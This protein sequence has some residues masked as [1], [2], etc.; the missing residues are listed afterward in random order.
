ML[1]AVELGLPVELLVVVVFVVVEADSAV[2]AVVAE[3]GVVV[4]A[5]TLERIVAQSA[6]T[7]YSQ[8]EEGRGRENHDDG[9]DVVIVVD[10]LA[11]L[12]GSVVQK[13]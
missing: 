4:V 10:P 11:A 12:A 7:V 6:R 8:A 2:A 5:R 13:N 9:V 3:S 1:E